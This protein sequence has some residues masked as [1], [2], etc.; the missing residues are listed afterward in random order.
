[1][2]HDK[3]LIEGVKDIIYSF[4][5]SLSDGYEY[6][7]KNVDDTIFCLAHLILT[8]LEMKEDKK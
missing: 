2:E 6:Y 3:K 4:E 8:Y 1:M 7:S 5:D